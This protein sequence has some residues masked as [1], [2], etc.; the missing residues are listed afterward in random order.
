MKKCIQTTVLA[1]TMGL[2]GSMSLFAGSDFTAIV[3]NK[4]MQE[5]MQRIQA[6]VSH[7]IAQ[8]GAS[9]VPTPPQNLH[10]TLKEIG[11]IGNSD[12]IRA[13]CMPYLEEAALKTSQFIL[14]RAFSGAHLRFNKQG[15]CMLYLAP[16]ASLTGLAHEIESSLKRAKKK[17]KLPK[18]MDRFDFP[19]GGHI[20]LGSVDFKN[21]TFKE[22]APVFG[23]IES[24]FDPAK[25]FIH[26]FPIEKFVLLWSNNPQQP[27]VYQPKMTFKLFNEKH[28]EMNPAPWSPAHKS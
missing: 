24:R 7:R 13:S 25:A 15:L 21:K 26:V 27:R 11:D 23:S 6:Y 5:A 18:L 9:F 2:A 28:E 19:H 1:V 17:D 12:S 20:T 8:G 16:D 14:D 4:D 22:L 10:I 3:L